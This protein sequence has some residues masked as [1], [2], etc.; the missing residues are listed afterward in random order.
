MD[1]QYVLDIRIGNDCRQFLITEKQREKKKKQRKRS[2]P[3][4]LFLFLPL[5]CSCLSSR[6]SPLVIFAKRDLGPL[7]CLVARRALAASSWSKSYG[8]ADVLFRA[9][10]SGSSSSSGVSLFWVNLIRFGG[11]FAGLVLSAWSLFLL[12]GRCSSSFSSL[13]SGVSLLCVNLLMV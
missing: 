5:P 13:S 10:C 6:C 8:L 2:P 7:C 1:I 11:A 12:R 4:S 3:Q 9:R